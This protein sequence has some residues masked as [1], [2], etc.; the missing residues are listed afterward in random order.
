MEK[1]YIVYTTVYLVYITKSLV[2]GAENN[3]KLYV[4]EW[5]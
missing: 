1:S 2:I 4:K 5:N 3:E